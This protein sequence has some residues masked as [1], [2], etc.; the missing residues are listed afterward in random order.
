MVVLNANEKQVLDLI[1][2]IPADRRRLILYELAKGSETAWQKNT[3]L[4]ETQLHKLA[5]ERGINWDEMD[6]DQ[7]QDFV[8]DLLRHKGDIT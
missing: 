7:R 8:A 4:A 1:Y 5:A 6:D 2:N 3:T